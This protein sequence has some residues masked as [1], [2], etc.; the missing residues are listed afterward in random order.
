MSFTNNN[1]NNNNDS[2]SDNINTEFVNFFDGTPSNN[3][4]ES[5]TNANNNNTHLY[6][7]IQHP[8][9][10]ANIDTGNSANGNNFLHNDETPAILLEQLAYIDNFIPQLEDDLHGSN[11]NISNS[12]TEPHT[13]EFNTENTNASNN[14]NSNIFNSM[15]ID[16]RL[17]AELSVFAHET[18]IFP[19]EDKNTNGND[20]HDIYDDTNHATNT[21]NN[22][23]NNTVSNNINNNPNT[24][25][26]IGNNNTPDLPKH[27]HLTDRKRNLLA[28]QYDLSRKRFSTKN[29]AN[30]SSPNNNINITSPQSSNVNSNQFFTNIN[31]GNTPIPSN[32]NSFDHGGFTNVDILDYNRTNQI[33][34]I[35]NDATSDRN[36]ITHNH[37]NNSPISDIFS[38]HMKNSPNEFSVY[39][40]TALNGNTN[41]IT[42]TGSNNSGNITQNA[43]TNSAFSTVP[44]S[45]LISKFPKVTVPH[46]AKESLLQLGLTVDQIDS[47]A[48]IVSYFQR[49]NY[50]FTD[51]L[52]NNVDNLNSN[53]NTNHIL[54]TNDLLLS[55]LNNNSVI[56]KKRTLGERKEEEEKEEKEERVGEKGGGGNDVIE[57][58]IQ[59]GEEGSRKKKK[60]E[61]KRNGQQKQNKEKEI[62]QQKQ[63]EK[64]EDNRTLDLNGAQSNDA[65]KSKNNNS[66]NTFNGT[67]TTDNGIRNDTTSI[68]KNKENN[69]NNNNNNNHSS[70]KNISNIG[71]SSL[72]NDCSSSDGANDNANKN[73]NKPS[74]RARN[75][76]NISTNDETKKDSLENRISELS[77]LAVDL[78]NKIRKLELENKLLKKLVMERGGFKNLEDL[79]SLKKQ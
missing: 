76:A 45:I 12:N 42:T 77:E 44:T 15:N 11:A 56:K 39:T 17:A 18:F 33:E 71:S 53:N 50:R 6:N 26:I 21:M 79:D 64:K 25:H 19:D 54:N 2:N 48:V 78:K 51:N 43:N 73:D 52:V 10:P 47:I 27:K 7:R 4:N 70:K 3:I 36:N 9:I 28:K 57:Q 59:D 16:D 66:V 62:V 5:N 40:P 14:G 75:T 61:E 24:N 69:N 49:E 68:D 37:L 41:S 20:H 58:Q 1:N 46:G 22:E 31:Q 38:P 23:L 8:I 30:R 35:N 60:K 32:T 29:N 55:F 67:I 74:K 63:Q 72:G 65:K 34:R 13:F